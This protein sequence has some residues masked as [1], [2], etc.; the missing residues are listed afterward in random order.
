LIAYRGIGL[1]TKK[2]P[3]VRILIADDNRDAMQ[4]LG[5]LFRS[6]GHEVC[7]VPNGSAAIV[8]AEAFRPDVAL[9]DL[10]MPGAS[11]LVVAHALRSYGAACPVLIAVTGMTSP[12]DR[13]KAEIS[14]F[15]HFIAK[16][17]DPGE[18]LKLV[19]SFAERN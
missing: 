2:D 16:P 19:S 1:P 7:L 13:K 4:T 14:G 5:I 15:H 18:L 3:L 17:Y 10:D 6:E 9:L 11:G 12:A 8:E